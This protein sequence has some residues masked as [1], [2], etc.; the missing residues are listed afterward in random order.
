M[1]KAS[2]TTNPTTST[3]GNQG[4]ASLELRFWMLFGGL[5]VA[6]GWVWASFEL[7]CRFALASI[8]LRSGWHL[9]SLILRSSF[10]HPSLG[11]APERRIGQK[12]RTRS[13]AAAK[14]PPSCQ[15]GEYWEAASN[16]P[17]T[18][19]ARQSPNAVLDA[20]ESVGWTE[21]FTPFPLKHPTKERAEKV[22]YSTWVNY[23]VFSSVSVAQSETS[24]SPTARTTPSRL[25]KKC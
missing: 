15:Q 24:L 9:A 19:S 8:R 25:E 18:T 5:L 23:P 14:M 4:A 16:V 21:S 17:A 7:G 22:S 2:N 6:C 13:V 12:Q 11:F 1:N 20:L 3:P 10:A